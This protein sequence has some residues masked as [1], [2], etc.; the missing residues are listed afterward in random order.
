MKNSDI[1][2]K[3]LILELKTVEKFT[4]NVN[5]TR[6]FVIPKGVEIK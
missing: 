6:Q 2:N 3:E 4:N 5:S 1:Q